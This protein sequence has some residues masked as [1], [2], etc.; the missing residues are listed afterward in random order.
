MTSVTD[1]YRITGPSEFLDVHVDRD[2]ELFVD[3]R[4]IRLQPRGS[5]FA[6]AANFCTTTFFNEVVAAVLADDASRGLELL[7]HFNE[8]KETR[9][10][11]ARTGYDGH[12]GSEEIGQDL[13][14]VLSTDLEALIRVG[15]LKE[16]EAI[17][18]FVK[19]I[20]SDITSDLT[21]RIIFEPLAEFTAHMVRTHPEFTA[22]QN[23]TRMVERQVWEPN[24][25]QWV[26]KPLELPNADGRPLLLVPRDW[27]RPTLL[28]NADRFFDKTVLDF[29]QLEQMKGRHPRTGKAIVPSKDDLREQRELRQGRGTNLTVTLRAAALDEDL[30]AVFADFV[31]G[32]YEPVDDEVLSRK[33]A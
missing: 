32:K 33:L 1:F 14:T 15:R 3:P 4:S 10:G 13:W 19:G 20:G 2:S 16:L 17:P 31:D 7:Q 6:Q 27:A 28:M 9:L 21:T 23:E 30:V 5:H 18:L 29:V 24:S 12:G 26:Y 8:P 25:N 11:M 22:G